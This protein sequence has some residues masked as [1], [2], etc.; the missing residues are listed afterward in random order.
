MSTR[1][2]L[3]SASGPDS[4]EA[5]PAR[6]GFVPVATPADPEALQKLAWTGD[7]VLGLF[8]RRHVLARLGRIDTPA[9]LELT[10]N[11]FLSGLGPPTRVEAEIGLVYERDG[12]DAAFAYIEA[13]VVPLWRAQQARRVRQRR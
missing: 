13:R 8:A 2:P 9:F 1:D 4:A 5:A 10:S 7:A 6:A 12:L 3:S 11:A